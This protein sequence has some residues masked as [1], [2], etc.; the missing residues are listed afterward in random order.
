MVAN[1]LPE[2]LHYLLTRHAIDTG[3][4]PNLARLSTLAELPEQETE[5][6]LR[7]LAEMHGVILVP[8]SLTIWSL[9]PFALIPTQF[10]VTAKRG[11]W[12]ANCAW[13]S[14]GIGAALQEASRYPPQTAPSGNRSN[15]A[16]RA[17]GPLNLH[18]APIV[19]RPRV[20]GRI[21]LRGAPP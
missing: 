3:H 2:R 7:Q 4:A 12:W 5:R 20:S 1:N 6:G 19:T 16:S 18:E 14:L 13:C 10:W 15:F 21:V 8:N 17:G 11:G 9:H